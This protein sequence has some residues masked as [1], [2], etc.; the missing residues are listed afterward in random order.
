MSVELSEELV[1]FIESGVWTYLA[2]R[3]AELR[4]YAA[5]VCGTAA[6][7]DRRQVTVWVEAS[8]AE[9]TIACLEHDRR[10]AISFSRSV[11]HRTIQLKGRAIRWRPSDPSERAMQERY[12]AAFSEQLYWV[13]IPRAVTRRLRCTPSLTLCVTPHEI[14]LQTPGPEAGRR[15]DPQA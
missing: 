7:A 1:E 4:P 6:G 10:A 3:D 2:T 9:R 14:F 11:D 13:G 12:L 15:L 5:R 8:A